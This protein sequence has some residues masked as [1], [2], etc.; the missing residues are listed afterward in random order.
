MKRYL[1]DFEILT[2]D[3][4]HYWLPLALRAVNGR[5]ATTVAERI[6]HGLKEKFDVQRTGPY[7]VGSYGGGL[8]EEMRKGRRQGQPAFL[9]VIEHRIRNVEFNPA[10]TF[11]EHMELAVQDVGAHLPDDVNIIDSLRH[12][13]IPVRLIEEGEIEGLR[14]FLVINIISP[15]VPDQPRSIPVESVELGEVAGKHFRATIYEDT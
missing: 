9:E 8:L 15:S 4:Q 7:V 14:A 11:D 3:G 10:M 5:K 1:V 12:H 13:R 2:S 6:E